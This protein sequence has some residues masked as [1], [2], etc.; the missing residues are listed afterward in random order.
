MGQTDEVSRAARCA[1]GS[2]RVLFYSVPCLISSYR[3]HTR[4]SPLKTFDSIFSSPWIGAEERQRLEA[5]DVQQQTR[6]SKVCWARFPSPALL[7]PPSR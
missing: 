6:R 7:H 5:R 1:P 2:A 3:Y 4:R